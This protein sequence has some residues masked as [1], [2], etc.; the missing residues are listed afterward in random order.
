MSAVTV[1]RAQGLFDLIGGGWPLL[2]PRS[3]EWVFGPET[4]VWLQRATAGLLA[5]TGW[6]LPRTG[7]APES[8]GQARRAGVGSAVTLPAVDLVHVPLG[9]IRPTYLL[10]AAM[11]A[12]RP[13]AWWRCGKPG[14][15]P[16]SSARSAPRPR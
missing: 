9:R 14:G 16:R 1:A 10:D 2:H 13:A 11:Q 12:G 6:S 4:D 3:F 7:P 5:T 15:K 8:L